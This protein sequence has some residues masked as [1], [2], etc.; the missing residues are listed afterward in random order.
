MNATDEHPR[1]ESLWT[2]EETARYLH[3]SEAWVYR[4][5]A[6]GEI[7]AAKLGRVYRFSPA[8]IRQY[9]AQLADRGAGGNVIRLPLKKR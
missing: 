3:M 1:E 8:R 4:R 7:P 9:A 5:T 2:V 6:A